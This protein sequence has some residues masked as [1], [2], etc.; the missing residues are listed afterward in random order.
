MALFRQDD[1]KDK[2]E[3]MKAEPVKAEPVKNEPAGKSI[4]IVGTGCEITGDMTPGEILKY[5][6]K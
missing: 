5:T 3:P 2:A 4:T 1:K 6:G